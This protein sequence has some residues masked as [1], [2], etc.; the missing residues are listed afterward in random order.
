MCNMITLKLGVSNVR[1]KSC[2]YYITEGRSSYSACVFTYVKIYDIFSLVFL[3]NEWT[4]VSTYR[5]LDS[6]ALFY[7]SICNKSCIINADFSPLKKGYIYSPY[8]KN[9]D[10]IQ[11]QM[12][13][14]G[15][16]GVR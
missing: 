1:K 7:T 11:M 5:N 3:Y 15:A 14:F 10:D 16:C 9:K 6:S 12:S 13:S 4:E 8:N 2:F